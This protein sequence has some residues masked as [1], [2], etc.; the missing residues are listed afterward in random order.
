MIL[1]RITLLLL[2]GSRHLNAIDFVSCEDIV[3]A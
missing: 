3:K 1:L 2:I